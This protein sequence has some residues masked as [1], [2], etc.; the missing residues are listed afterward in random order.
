MSAYSQDLRDRILDALEQGER[1][2]A[3][4]QRF[5]VSRSWVY[6]V[7]ERLLKHGQRSALQVGGYRRSRLEPF[8]LKIRDWIQEQ[9][10]LTLSE[11]CARLSDLGVQI[12]VPALWH[13]L[14]KWGLSFKKNAARQRARTRGCA[15][16]AE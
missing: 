4:A 11:M 9:P 2:C 1:P 13:Q 3:I 15:G 12:K 5:V 8:E 16:S 14:N 6:R 7:R 10:D